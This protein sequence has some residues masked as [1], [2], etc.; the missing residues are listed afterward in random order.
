MES[1]TGEMEEKVHSIIEKID[2]MGG[3]VKAVEKGWIHKEISIAAYE[4]QNAIESGEMPIVGV[5]CFKIEDE[6][7]PIELFSLPETLSVQ[8]KKLEKIKKERSSK[9]AQSDKGTEAQRKKVG[10]VPQTG[11]NLPRSPLIKGGSEMRVDG[12][13]GSYF[14]PL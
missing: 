11:Q 9:E 3:I 7:L 8:K 12:D 6:E 10:P 5:N 2:D 1:L 14:V 13:V 4:Y